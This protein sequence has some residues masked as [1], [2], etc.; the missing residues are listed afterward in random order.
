MVARKLN[1]LRLKEYRFIENKDPHG[2]YDRETRENL[3]WIIEKLGSNTSKNRS[4]LENRLYKKFRDADFGFLL[5]KNTSTNGVITFDGVLCIDGNFEGEIKGPQTLIVGETGIVIANVTADIFILKGTVRG[6]VVAISKAVIHATA[7]LLG[8]IKT[9]CLHIEEG[10]QF[11]GKCHMTRN[12]GKVPKVKRQRKRN[13][14][15]AG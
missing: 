1:V 6:N 8:N 9:P 13:F 7:E 4:S 11:M 10:A 2:I 3:Y 12:L 5:S 14:F 15:L